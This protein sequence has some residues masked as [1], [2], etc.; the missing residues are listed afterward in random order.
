MKFRILGSLDPEKFSDNAFPEGST[1]VVDNPYYYG[2]GEILFLILLEP[3]V[4]LRTRQGAI[5][6]AHRFCKI[7]TYDE[8]VIKALPE[9]AVPIIYTATSFVKEE[10]ALFDISKKEFA[11]SS[12]AGTKIFPGV[13]GHKLREILY[14]NHSLFPKNVTFFRSH[15]PFGNPPQL[16]PD[17]CGNPFFYETKAPWYQKFQFAITIENSQQKNWFS[18]K[19]LDCLVTK[20]IPIYCGC[21]NIS[22]YFDTSGW[23]L[24]SDIIELSEKIKILTPD[25]YS[26]FTKV[27]EENYIKAIDY[28][29]P[30]VN[31]ERCAKKHF[32]NCHS[33]R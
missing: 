20:C 3:E 14:F 26:R 10:L 19:L 11:V 15:R 6:N 2:S 21:T 5:E 32:I 31:I 18:E 28:A 9:K 30:E 8:E 16:L 29:I 23:I 22:D 12:W 4:I 25:Y 27:I 33:A 17:L 1:I 13:W 24:F 7:Y